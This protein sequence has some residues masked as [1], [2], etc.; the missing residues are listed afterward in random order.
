MDC[1]SLR[2]S[3]PI[4]LKAGIK[5]RSRV[6]TQPRCKIQYPMKNHNKD[7]WKKPQRNAIAEKYFL[8]G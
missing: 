2:G 1:E 4:I 8:N 6:E 3:C 7:A 5:N